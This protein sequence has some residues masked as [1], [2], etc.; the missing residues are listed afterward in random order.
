MK[1][2]KILIVSGEP[3]GDLHASNLIKNI[4]ALSPTTS[5]DVVGGIYSK[6]NNVN[7]IYDIKNL[8]FMGFIEILKNLKVIKEFKNFIFNKIKET[9][10]DEVVLIDYPG[11]NLKIAEFCYRLK[12]PV[13]YYICPQIW[14]WHYS[15]IHKIIKYCSKILVIFK[16]EKDLYLKEGGNVFFTGHPILDVWNNYHIKNEVNDKTIALIPGSRSQEIKRILPKMIEIVRL[17]KDRLNDYKFICSFMNKELENEYASILPDYIDYYT[18]DYYEILAKAD[19][20]LTTSGTATLETALFGVPLFVLYKVNMLSAL[21]AKA[22]IKI[23]Y[24]SLVNIVANKKIVEE[25]MQWNLKTEI[26]SNKMIRILKNK[27]EYNKIKT[28]LLKF[29]EL[30]MNDDNISPS[31]LAAKIIVNK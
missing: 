3:S 1:N 15:R 10:Y 29:K 2:R 11:M 20:S 26:I 25:Y 22:L 31:E 7:I 28:E 9:N 27:N 23:P 17:A 14:A 19:F 5:I 4:L 21:I 8:S 18:G 24:L 12:I 6:K 30:L 13:T 16:F